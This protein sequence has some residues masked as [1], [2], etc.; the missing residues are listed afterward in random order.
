MQFVKKRMWR[1]VGDVLKIA[2]KY[3]H[4]ILLLIYTDTIANIY[5]KICFKKFKHTHTY[6]NENVIVQL[7]NQ[8]NQLSR[9]VFVLFQKPPP[10][11]SS[12]INLL[13]TIIRTVVIH[14]IVQWIAMCGKARRNTLCSALFH[15]TP[16]LAWPLLVVG[17]V[18]RRQIRNVGEIELRLVAV[19]VA[20]IR[21]GVV[22]V[23]EGLFAG[24]T[25]GEEFTLFGVAP[26]HTAI[27]EPDFHLEQRGKIH[28]ISGGVDFRK[29][30]YSI[31]AI[32]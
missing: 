25:G 4:L 13:L 9:C 1:W 14:A 20:Q 21:V 27:L 3:L 31:V 11:K 26:F 8:Q 17:W 7:W 15:R 12:N 6:F 5:I 30:N 19:R 22:L 29:I 16:R 24:T 32:A 28:A 23:G 2:L 18:C 10:A